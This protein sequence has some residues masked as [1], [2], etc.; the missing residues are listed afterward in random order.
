MTSAAFAAAYALDWIAGD[1]QWLPHPVRLIGA[2]IAVGE[3]RLLGPSGRSREMAR[4]ALLTGAIVGG[5]Y[6]AARLAARNRTAEIALAWTALATRSL[7][8]ESS[9]VL[10]A[11][12]EG[13]LEKSRRR[14]AGIVGR[15][16]DRLNE[17]EI[18]RAVIETLAES[19]CDGI[20]APMMYLAAGG[21]PLAL[22]FKAAST[23]DSMIGHREP[24][25]LYFGRAAARLD[26]IA[27]F[28]PARVAAVGILFV[29]WTVALCRLSG[30]GERRQVAAACPPPDTSAA[31]IWLRDGGKHPS[32][33]AGQC[34]AAMAGALGVRLGGINFYDGEPSEKPVLCAEGRVPVP[35]DARAAMRI[36][37]I[38]SMLVFAAAWFWLRRRERCE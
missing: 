37:G 28:A 29:G 12:D 34:E 27:N 15:D 6:A 17:A 23:L 21:A 16:T 22:A 31:G 8:Q 36:V 24:P 5:T 30:L 11:L 14:L 20:V 10:D 19:L 9:A 35:A 33:N 3:R 18:V 38:A 1:P 26:D 32:P 7:L 4:G 2:A 13:D 25:Y